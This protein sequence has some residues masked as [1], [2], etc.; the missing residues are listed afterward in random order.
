MHRVN[1]AIIII[2]VIPI[3]L[4]AA[5]VAISFVI[6][7]DAFAREGR[8]T[9]DT[10]QA[11]AVSNECL[12]PIFDSNEDIDNAV[13]VGNCG[14]TVSQQDESGQAS[15]P[16]THQTANPAI[17]LQRATTSQPPLTVETCE[18]CFGSL[19]AAQVSEFESS[20]PENFGSSVTTI[21]QLCDF[22]A[23]Q[24]EESV[25]A[26]IDSVGDILEGLPQ[27]I[28]PPSLQTILAIENCLL[29]IFG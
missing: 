8:Y 4:L 6:T 9:G 7:E 10:S 3:L 23:A 25:P 22:I 14:G 11:A 16:I 17:E 20:L 12:N 19:T 28:P 1:L 18:D 29:E 5:T 2:I 27:T 15:A 26:L 21:E 13:G 24:Q